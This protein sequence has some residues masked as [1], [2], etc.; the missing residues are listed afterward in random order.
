MARRTSFPCLSEAEEAFSIAG[1]TRSVVT[2]DPLI[3]E[4]VII[5][6]NEIDLSDLARRCFAGNMY[7]KDTS[8]AIK[9]LPAIVKLMKNTQFKS[10]WLWVGMKL[11]LAKRK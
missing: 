9:H 2:L 11:K 4:S 7:K 8:K 3:R 1:L 6:L 5:P 10:M